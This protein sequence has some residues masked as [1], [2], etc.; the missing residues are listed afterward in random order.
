M[1]EVSLGKYLRISK[2]PDTEI[3]L[4]HKVGSHWN[5]KRGKFSITSKV[6][7]VLVNNGF[8]YTHDTT[9]DYPPEGGAVFRKRIVRHTVEES[10]YLLEECLPLENCIEQGGLVERVETRKLCISQDYGFL[11]STV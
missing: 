2:L 1:K 3:L 4:K 11:G 10:T 7:I 5:N 6:E 9:V 8:V